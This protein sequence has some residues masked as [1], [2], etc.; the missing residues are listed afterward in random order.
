[1]IANI[2]LF[3]SNAESYCLILWPEQRSVTVVPESVVLGDVALGKECQVKMGRKKY[4]GQIL[5]VGTC[6]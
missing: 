4:T 6:V 1:M 3:T 2:L 5:A